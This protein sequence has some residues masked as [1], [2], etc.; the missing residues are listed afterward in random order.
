MLA[1][2]LNKKGGPLDIVKDFVIKTA[3][4]IGTS[5]WIEP[6]TVP[7]NVVMAE[8]PSIV[9]TTMLKNNML[10]EWYQNTRCIVNTIK[11]QVQ[12]SF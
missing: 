8:M 9:I 7:G 12:L 5:F 2:I 10:E 4:Y 11:M 6:G 1:I 3:G